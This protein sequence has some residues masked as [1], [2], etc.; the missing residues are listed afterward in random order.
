MSDN[1]SLLNPKPIL[2]T[3]AN[4]FLGRHLV[5]E[6]HGRGHAVRALVRPGTALPFPSEWGV[7]Y[8]EADLARPA[9]LAGAA[10]GCGAIIHAA[11][12][13][14]VNPA[15]NPALW[16]VNV[17]GTRAV[18]AEARRA[19]V[20]RLVYVGTANVFGFGTREN[21][22]DETR[23]YAG[24]RY[25]L[26]YMES[27][28]AATD[29]VL[30]A[31][32]DEQL[33]AVL[34]HPTFMLGPNDAKPTSGALLLEIYRGK[35]PG[36]PPGGKNYVHVRDVAHATVN[37]LHLGKVGESY[38]LGNEN[39]S[40]REALTLMADLMRVPAPRWPLPAG[41]AQLYG[42]LCSLQTRLTGRP[43][44]LNAAMTAV[45]NDGHYFAVEKARRELELPQT[46]VAQAITDAFAWFQAEQY[47]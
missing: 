27:K 7:S 4:G 6:L 2:V 38:I 3:G 10:T 37:A 30:A 16:A 46:P 24:T 5:S 1:Q 8:V 45:A 36:Y 39:L 31:V 19:G 20:G 9:T 29:L 32:A 26:D 40:Y 11:A 13:A 34:V 44:R 43:G 22:G 14:S 21:P 15:R 47:I 41:L 35:V 23:P 18:L 33:P 25:G 42:E 17:E 28:R 12:L